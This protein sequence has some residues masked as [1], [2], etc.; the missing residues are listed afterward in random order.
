[1]AARFNQS[2]RGGGEGLSATQ[3]TRRTDRVSSRSVLSRSDDGEQWLLNFKQ[4]VDSL[5][6]DLSKIGEKIFSSSESLENLFL[7]IFHFFFI[8]L[9]I[10]KKIIIN[11]GILETVN[12]FRIE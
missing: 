10:I 2:G 4:S 8:L 7:V 12:V 6:V 5:I 1:M 9:I 11:I 3:T